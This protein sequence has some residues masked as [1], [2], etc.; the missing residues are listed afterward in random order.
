ML[1]KEITKQEAVAV[2]HWKY[3]ESESMHWQGVGVGE[4]SLLQPREFC[5]NTLENFMN[6]G[7]FCLRKYD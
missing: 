4:D 5:G 6:F 1:W 3:W 7:G 2:E